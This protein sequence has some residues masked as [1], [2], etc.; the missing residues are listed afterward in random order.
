MMEIRV[1][2]SQLKR[3]LIQVDGL[4]ILEIQWMDGGLDKESN[5]NVKAEFSM[6]NG[7]KTE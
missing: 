6:E 5:S 2:Y 7:R 4:S 3:V 1:M